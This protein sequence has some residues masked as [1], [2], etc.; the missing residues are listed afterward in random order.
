KRLQST[1]R[2][3]RFG[4]DA[5]SAPAASAAESVRLALQMSSRSIV[6]KINDDALNSLFGPVRRVTEENGN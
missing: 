1:G 6:G 4:S 3:S 2:R 5:G